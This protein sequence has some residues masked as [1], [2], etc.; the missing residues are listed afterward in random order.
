MEATNNYRV[1]LVDDEPFI[2][3]ALRRE[4][5]TPPLG[6]N[7]YEVVTETNP[8]QALELAKTQNFDLVV[9]D[10]MMPEMD[11][12][13]FLDAFS[14]IQPD[15][16][17][18]ILSGHA[19]MQA[20]LNAV[21]RSHVYRFITKPW[22]DYYLKGSVSQALAWREQTLKNRRLADQARQLQL[23]Q[24][25]AGEARQVFQILVVDD[26]EGVNSAIQREL[27]Y[28]SN[29]EAYLRAMSYERTKI[30]IGD[31]RKYE[32]IVFTYTSAHKALAA[33]RDLT[34]DCVIADYRMAEMDGVEFL[35][36]FEAMQP[37][38]ARI[39]M[40]AYNDMDV[41][42]GA[43]NSGHVFAFIG[44]PWNKYDLESA[45]TQA[46]FHSR[47]ERENRM[48]AAYIKQQGGASE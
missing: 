9:S 21:N 6:R 2:L 3:S 8:L 29:L 44:K 40:S 30:T 32:F 7:R 28:Q 31:E 10:Y 16:A 36:V 37:D 38:C 19:D 5:L 26:D 17:R 33:A 13:S 46:I 4:L 11:G 23:A 41:I 34:F 20:V 15:A 25:E 24:Q 22:H 12:L 48:L 45:V 42:L 43:L 35:Q 47:A 18:I 27:T 39:M 14:K 1:L